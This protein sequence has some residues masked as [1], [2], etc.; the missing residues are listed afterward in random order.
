MN[1]STI[2]HFRGESPVARG[3]KRSA[4]KT[5]NWAVNEEATRINVFISAK[6]TFKIWVSA[7]HISGEFARRLKYMAN[8]AAKN[9]TSLPSQ[10]IVPTEVA[11]GRFTEW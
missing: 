1:H 4:A 7:D 8:K 9:M 6:G 10:T 5:P 3:C 11:L 2:P